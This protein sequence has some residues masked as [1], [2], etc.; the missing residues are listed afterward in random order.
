MKTNW[1]LIIVLSLL[2][3]NRAGKE[4]LPFYNTPDFTPHW[5][6]AGGNIASPIHTIAA[7]SFINQNGETISNKNVEDKI[8][9]ANFF[10]TTCA[11]ICPKMM[12]NLKKVEQ[13]FRNKQDV[14]ILSHSVMP[15][16]DS[17]QR[18]SA[19]A[20]RFHINSNQ[21]WLLTGNKNAI[22]TMARQSY[23]AE[24]ENGYNKKSNEFLHTENCV[25]IDR[26]GRIRGVYNATLE[27]EMNKLIEH[28]KILRQED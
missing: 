26:R 6:E 14:L 17:A 5:Q 19:Y 11:G 13:A 18:L 25:L 21:W 15:E 8:Y 3:C 2:A 7:F 10:F 22:Y 12:K 16:T 24:E 1:I 9:V 28:I 23:F 4:K 27:L 20:K